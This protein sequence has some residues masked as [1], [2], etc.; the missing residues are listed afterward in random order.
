M[1]LQVLFNSNKRFRNQGKSGLISFIFHYLVSCLISLSL[2][3]RMINN[4]AGRMEHLIFMY[5]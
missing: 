5:D 1:G 2:T 4:E 3:N